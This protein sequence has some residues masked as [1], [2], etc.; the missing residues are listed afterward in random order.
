MEKERVWTYFG[1]NSSR[2]CF[3]MNFP[4]FI[5]MKMKHS[6]ATIWMESVIQQKIGLGSLGIQNLG[7]DKQSGQ[8]Q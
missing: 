5:Y 7:Y 2:N 8:W 1:D 3:N 6:K 4:S